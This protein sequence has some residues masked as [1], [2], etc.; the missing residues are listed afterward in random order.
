MNELFALVRKRMI[1]SL[2]R[3]AGA[4]ADTPNDDGKEEFNENEEILELE[5]SDE[6]KR[7]TRTGS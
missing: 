2:H 3:R 5:K 1:C 6:R 7:L 4:F